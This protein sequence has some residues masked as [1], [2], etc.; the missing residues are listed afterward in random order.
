MTVVIHEFEVVAEKPPSSEPAGAAASGQPAPVT[1]PTPQDI[2][3]V[4]RRLAER[5]AR[6]RAH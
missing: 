2:D 5:C 4:V 1:P 6:V 3:R